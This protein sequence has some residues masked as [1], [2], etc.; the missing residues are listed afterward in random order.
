[1][2]TNDAGVNGSARRSEQTGRHETDEPVTRHDDMIVDRE[3][4]ELPGLHQLAGHRLIFRRGG[5]VSAGVVVNHDDPRGG[6]GNGGAE[7]LSRVHQGA[8]K[9][10]TGD[11]HVPADPALAVEGQDVEFFHR[12][13]PEPGPEQSDDVRRIPNPRLGWTL[14]LKQAG[15]ELECRQQPGGLGG[16]NPEAL[17]ELRAGA[18]GQLSEGST[19]PLQQAGG[20]LRRAPAQSAG[21]KENGDEF[22]GSEG[23]GTE[24]PEPLAGAFGGR[25]PL[26]LG[27]GDRPASTRKTRQVPWHFLYFLPDP[28]GQGS[29]RPTVEIG[30]AHV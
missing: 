27:P 15:G 25:H 20:N 21:A 10:P 22:G 5:W 19:A 1:M 9:Q 12:Q 3:I 11:Q 18:G 26:M 4:Q 23:G 7:D 14:F 29:F 8:V 6:L 2:A 24:R 16:T 30:R 17:G 13:V 28:Q